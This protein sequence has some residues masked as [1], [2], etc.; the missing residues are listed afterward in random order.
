MNGVITNFSDIPLVAALTAFFF[1]RKLAIRGIAG[2]PAP[3]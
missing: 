3:I 1:G 2:I